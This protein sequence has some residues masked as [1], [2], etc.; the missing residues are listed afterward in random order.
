M[1]MTTATDTTALTTET[2][3][4]FLEGSDQ[5]YTT[6]AE[7]FAAADDTADGLRSDWYTVTITERT[8]RT[9]HDAHGNVLEVEEEDDDHEETIQ[10]DPDEPECTHA[11]GHDW[12]QP[13]HLVGGLREFP[14]EFSSGG[15]MRNEYACVRCGCGYSVD[16]WG[17]CPTDGTRG[18]RVEEYTPGEYEDQLED[19]D[20]AA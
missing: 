3:T 14:G 1:T 5:P 18:H 15:G 7:A 16:T 13:H 6:Y 11:D 19:E 4:Y 17:R 10:C 12:Q 9:T 8:T 20:A 2:T